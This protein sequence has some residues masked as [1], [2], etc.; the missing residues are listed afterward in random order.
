MTVKKNLVLGG[1]QERGHKQFR[2]GAQKMERGERLGKNQKAERAEFLGP[3]RGKHGA[4][5]T[6]GPVSLIL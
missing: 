1:L 4:S 3:W 6:G 2:I 5:V